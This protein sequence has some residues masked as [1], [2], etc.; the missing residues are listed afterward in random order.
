MWI[1]IYFILNSFF[2]A[3]YIT[4]YQHFGFWLFYL[5][6]DIDLAES[7]W[8]N[9]KLSDI[10]AFYFVWF[11]FLS[12]CIHLCDFCASS[13]MM[14]FTIRC[15]VWFRFLFRVLTYFSFDKKWMGWMKDKTKWRDKQSLDERKEQIRFSNNLIWMMHLW[16]RLSKQNFE[17]NTNW[18][19]TVLSK[20][21]QIV[22]D[23]LSEAFEFSFIQF[24]LLFSRCQIQKNIDSKFKSTLL[25][26]IF[27][28]GLL[29]KKYIEILGAL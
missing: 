17:K 27:A 8:T 3:N 14:I 19:Q 25:N 21:F 7:K 2:S 12:L 9:G 24:F 4:F 28:H 1:A 20:K 16:T 15:I 29:L 11:M 18:F 26:S 22:T 10:Y 23:L 5:D 13:F 6:F